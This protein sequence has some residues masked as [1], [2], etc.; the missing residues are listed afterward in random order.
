M[1]LEA[2]IFD[3]DGTLAET[4]EVHRRAFN[5]SFAA[6]GLDW[7]WSTDLYRDLLR[8]AGGKERIRYYVEA[9]K[10]AQGD[11]ALA[12]LVDI[13]QQKNAFYAELVDRGA[14][15]PRPGV[16]ALIAEARRLGL[17]LAIATTTS[18]ANVDALL[19][20]SFGAG[21][22]SWFE[23]MG[24]GDCVAAKKPAPDIYH[25]VLERLGIAAS[26][27]LAFED[28]ENGVVAARSAGLAV[29]ATPGFYSCG[30]NFAAASIVLNDLE[31][32]PKNWPQFFDDA[33]LSL[34]I[35]RG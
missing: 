34:M 6:F 7:V 17:R 13:H 5:Q 19:Q 1:P 21:S 27:C 15:V 12:R 4:E 31:H 8:V 11:E 22:A 28:S 10:P 20:A 18:P 24:A 33:M 16:A 3:V 35:A 2:L 14:A 30:D 23:V 9:Y 25:F 26:A 29:V 32:M